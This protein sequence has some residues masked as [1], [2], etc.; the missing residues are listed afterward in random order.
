[1]RVLIACERSGVVRRAF[2]ARGYAAWSCDIEPA[3]DDSPYHIRHDVLDVI[4]G[5]LFKG[6]YWITPWDLMIAHP[7]C[8][9]LAV[10]GSRWFAEKRADGRQQS[11]IDFFMKLAQAPIPRIALEQPISI[12]SSAY[13]KPDQVIH[14]Y[15]FGHP[16]FKATSIWLKNLPLL[17]PTDILMPPHRDSEEWIAW[18]RVHRMPPGPDRAKN[19]SETYA[20]IAGAMAEQWGKETPYQNELIFE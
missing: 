1:L 9:D 2:R 15:Q 11:A 19:R 4:D 12:I 10:S 14:P 16:E 18:N 7:P 8:T 6:E 20:G 3:D 17:Q 13:R 5:W